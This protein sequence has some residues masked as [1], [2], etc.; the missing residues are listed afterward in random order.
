MQFAE[1]KYTESL[2]GESLIAKKQS[3]RKKSYLMNQ[4]HYIPKSN[5]VRIIYTMKKSLFSARRL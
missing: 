4:T 5:I 3:P 1:S 2:F